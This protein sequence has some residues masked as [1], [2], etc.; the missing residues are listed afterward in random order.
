MPWCFGSYSLNKMTDRDLAALRHAA[1]LLE[2]QSFAMTLAAKV[3]MPVE[4]LMRMLPANA[5]QGIGNAVN[6]AL[7]RSLH[8]ALNF[9]TGAVSTPR[10]RSLHTWT[11]AATGA[12]G[13]FFGLP[14]LLVELPV[15]TTVMLH[16]IAEI[17]RANG[18]DLSTPESA[19]RCWRLGRTAFAEAMARSK[20]PTTLP[21][22]RSHR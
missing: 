14:G 18:E 8:V 9:N 22:P 15:T 7:E 12:L 11:T 10:T 5:Q 3:G 1:T 20:A 13:G 17:A 16:S 6:K 21:A 4:G 19:W 2:S